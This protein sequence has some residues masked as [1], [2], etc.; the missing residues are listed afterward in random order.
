[1]RYILLLIFTTQI[2]LFCQTDSPKREFRGIWITTLENIDWPSKKRLTPEEQTA[3]FINIISRLKKEKI[4]AVFIQVRPACDAFYKSET[5][6]WSEWLTGR[7]GKEP[8]PFYDPLKFIV[9]ECH[10]RGIEIHAWFNPFRSVMNKQKSDVSGKH[11]SKTHPGWNI[12]YGKYKWLDP[13]LPEVRDYITG[14]VL[15]VV[16]RYNV[17][18][19]HFDDYFYPEPIK[20]KKFHDERTFA[21]Y[22]RGI[23]NSDMW[24]RDNINLFV[25]EVSDSI[26][27][28]RPGCSFGISP[29]G[30]WKNNG[31]DNSGSG[32]NGSESYYKTYADSK[33]WISEGWVDYLVPQLYWHIG[34]YIADYKKLA[35]WWSKN[36]FDRN[37]YIG[38]AV[39]KIANDHNSEWR[40]G[41]Q[42]PKQ[43]KIN[44]STKNISGN[45][46]FNTNTFLKNPLG[47]QDSLERDYYKY[48][49][50]TPVIKGKSNSSPLAPVN[51]IYNISNGNTVLRWEKP[52]AVVG[53]D[54]AVYFV[55]YRFPQ[56][57]TVDISRSD[58]IADVVY[59]T[60][61]SWMDTLAGEI[62][63]PS[64]QN[65]EHTSEYNYIV[66]SLDCYK[67]ESNDVCRITVPSESQ[68]RPTSTYY[69]YS[70]PDTLEVV[71]N[72]STALIIIKLD[73]L[74]LVTLKIFDFYGK[75]IKE[76]LHEYKKGGRYEFEFDHKNVKSSGY[77]VQMKTKGYYSSKRIYITGT[78][79]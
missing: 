35:D 15:D 24:R 22:S 31:T 62:K 40:N 2:H 7:Q 17:D 57:D 46:F 76:L 51:G 5:E 50:I 52:G 64:P 16:R 59:A 18:G 69:I 71:R 41:N 38:Q 6:P 30:I 37:I 47:L 39:Y 60:E 29:F 58:R 32:S 74:T 1:M 14:V 10:K 67:N 56:I 53:R 28:V 36:S 11:I 13:G 79:F 77:I 4:N 12:E 54:T 20:N 34:N 75:E 72:D 73:K 19:V 70:N 45:V 68:S 42:I 8:E 63:R 25:K 3:E 21:K 55:I 61:T 9:K 44:R 23:K 78:S 66:T 65:R 43:I 26:R 49:A 27:N 48:Y 33:K